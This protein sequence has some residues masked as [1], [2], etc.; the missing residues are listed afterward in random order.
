MFQNI[1]SSKLLLAQFTSAIYIRDV[2]VYYSLHSF[3]F[4][5]F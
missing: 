1:F 5:V 4:V 2:F 3:L